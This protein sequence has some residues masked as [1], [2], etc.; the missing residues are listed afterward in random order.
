MTQELHTT[1]DI[2]SQIELVFGLIVQKPW[3]TTVQ[4]IRADKTRCFHAQTV[5]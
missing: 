5:T 4:E 2:S 1:F 3:R